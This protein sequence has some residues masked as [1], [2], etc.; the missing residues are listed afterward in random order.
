[1]H[2]QW[3][4]EGAWSISQAVEEGLRRL[5]PPGHQL[6]LNE[7]RNVSRLLSLRSKAEGRDLDAYLLANVDLL[8]AGCQSYARHMRDPASSPELPDV[9]SAGGR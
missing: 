8:R 6:T 9:R 3:D 5:R 1:M 7:N 2:K 4:A